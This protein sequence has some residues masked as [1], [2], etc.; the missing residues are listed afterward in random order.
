MGFR[1]PQP[2]PYLKW[3]GGKRQLLP[4]L[5]SAVDA[6]GDFSRYHEPF[7]GGGALFF[8]LVRTEKIKTGI[9]LS[10]INQNL[11]DAYIGVCRDVEAVVSALK[12]HKRQHSERHYYVTRSSVPTSLIDRAARLIYLNKTCFN[13]LYR[14]NSKGQFNTPFGKYKNPAICDEDNLRAVA[15]TL[16][17][18]HISTRSFSSV[19]TSAEEGDL[20]YFDPPYIPISKTADFTAYSAEKFGIR[21][22]EELAQTFAKLAQKG[23]KV[24]LSN[25]LT[26]LTQKL[27]QGFYIS[28]VLAAR[29]VNSRASRRGKVSEAIIT[30]YPLVKDSSVSRVNVEPLLAKDWLLENGYSDVAR[31]IDEIESEWRVAGKQTRRNWWEVLSG[32]SNGKPRHVAGREFPVLRAAQARQGVKETENAISRSPREDPPAIRLRSPPS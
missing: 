2:R 8:S 4:A 6:A 16:S 21:Q 9:Y 23:V 15:K 22:H 17:K 26:A 30:G 1:E 7:L 19:L 25:S 29:R 14:E 11:I 20:V 18:A 28:S 10:D 32:D 31:L 12:D 3:A 24:I 5:L 13:G 27:Y